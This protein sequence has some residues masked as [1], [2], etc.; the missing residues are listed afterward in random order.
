M[1][2]PKI[3]GELIPHV[4]C[5]VPKHEGNSNQCVVLCMKQCAHAQVGRLG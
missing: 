5:C 4:F 3:G 2:T 1:I